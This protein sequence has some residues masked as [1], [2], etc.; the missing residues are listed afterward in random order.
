MGR[1]KDTTHG[2][3]TFFGG[4]RKQVFLILQHSDSGPPPFAA[5]AAI[6]MRHKR[7]I[8]GKVLPIDIVF[9]FFFLI[10]IVVVCMKCVFAECLNEMSCCVLDFVNIYRQKHRVQ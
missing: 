1:G 4:S 9:F 2:P 6:S 10:D 8:F 5:A 3:I 7:K